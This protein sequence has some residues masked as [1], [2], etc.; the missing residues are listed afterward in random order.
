MVTSAA[1]MNPT[2]I[3]LINCGLLLT[4][5]QNSLRIER[6]VYLPSGGTFARDAIRADLTVNGFAVS[7]IE[8]MDGSVSGIVGSFEPNPLLLT[9]IEQQFHVDVSSIVLRL[10]VP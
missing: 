10:A 2:S 1:F 8:I 6:L 5:S 9:L 3:E 7:G 4:S